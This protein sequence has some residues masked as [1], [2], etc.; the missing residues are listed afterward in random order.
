MSYISD[1]GEIMFTNKEYVLEVF[2][3]KSFSKAAKNLYVSQPSLS[4]SIKRIEDKISAPI[5]DR[6]TNPISITEIGMEYVKSSLEIK[7]IESN[8]LNYMND[9]LNILKGEIK[10]GG[11]S[12]FSSY[13]LPPMIAKFKQLYPHIDFILYEDNT[14]DLM[15]LL[16]EGE[17]DI[18]VDNT[19]IKNE[20]IRSYFYTTEMILLAVPKKSEINEALKEYQLSFDDI[21]NDIHLNSDFPCVSLSSFENEPFVLLKHENETGKRARQLCSNHDF[22]PNVIFEL[23]QQATAYNVTCSGMGI[24]FVSD[25]LIKRLSSQNNTV[26]Y[27]LNDVEVNRNIYFYVKNNRYLSNACRKFIDINI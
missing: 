27:K 18:V 26:Y 15:T 6:S 2:K 7:K 4:S 3:E 22:A 11:S 17:I 24:S 25:T 10:I 23:D 20:N 8:F 16:L 1:R 21:K 14:K 13:V 19:V 9:S 5:F 12:L